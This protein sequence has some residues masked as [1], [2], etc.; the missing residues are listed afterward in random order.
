M[1]P[2]EKQSNTP[3]NSP[4]VK[5]EIATERGKYVEADINENRNKS[6][7][8][9]MQLKEYLELVFLTWGESSG[10]L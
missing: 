9:G 3:L 1:G 5:E 2:K 7:L 6:K 8:M 4:W 10:I